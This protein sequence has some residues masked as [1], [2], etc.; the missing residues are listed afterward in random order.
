M[1]IKN[2]E[3]D[4]D[5]DFVKVHKQVINEKVTWDF[6]FYYCVQKFSASNILRQK[7]FGVHIITFG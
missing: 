6:D 5:F 7:S 2:T 1:G 3:F 4:A